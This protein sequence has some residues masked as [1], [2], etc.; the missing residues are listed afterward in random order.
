VAVFWMRDE[1]GPDAKVLCVPSTDPRWTHVNDLG[2]LP[3]FL[4]DEIGHFFEVY[5][6]L[7]PGKSTEPRGWEGAKAAE[8]AVSDALSRHARGAG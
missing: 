7:E 1:K 2:D 4:L 8:G 6:Q 3:A 5:K